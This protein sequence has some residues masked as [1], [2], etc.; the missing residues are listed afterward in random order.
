MKCMSLAHSSIRKEVTV[1]LQ[2]KPTW[3][4]AHREITVKNEVKRNEL[5]ASN[6]NNAFL[7]KKRTD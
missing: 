2:H 3:A 7:I 5:N 6:V 4:R 1:L